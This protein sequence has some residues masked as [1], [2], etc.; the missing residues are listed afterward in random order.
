MV[1]SK[2][3][4]V[5]QFL[6]ENDS[7][8]RPA[9]MAFRKMMKATSQKTKESMQYG[10]PTYSVLDK[11]FAAFNV[12]KHHLAVY[13]LDEELLTARKN[14]VGNVEF[15]KGCIRSRKFENFNLEVLTAIVNDSV[16]QRLKAEAIRRGPMPRSAPK[17]PTGT[18]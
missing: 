15:Q 12:E 7:V 10:M 1:T 4:N 2:A 6:N 13:I 5:D 9:L 8:M 11:P 18:K 16:E 14:D 17:N 3:R